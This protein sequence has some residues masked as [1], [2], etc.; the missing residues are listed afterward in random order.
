MELVFFWN[1]IV[2]SINVNGI[3]SPIRLPHLIK[4]NK[5]KPQNV[6]HIIRY[7]FKT[8]EFRKNEYRH[9]RQ[10]KTKRK[11]AGLKYEIQIRLI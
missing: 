11:K 5:I 9:T 10:I 6:C 4:P 2:I 7:T 1:I 8:K 3:I